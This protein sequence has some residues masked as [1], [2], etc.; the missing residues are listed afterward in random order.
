MVNNCGETFFSQSLDNFSEFSE[1]ALVNTVSNMIEVKVEK[2][3]L[4][5]YKFV[6]WRDK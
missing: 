1:L 6:I 2:S 3:G 4:E 5:R